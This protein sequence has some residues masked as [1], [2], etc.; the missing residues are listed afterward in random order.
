MSNAEHIARYGMKEQ[1]IALLDKA[2]I[3]RA[4]TLCG[5]CVICKKPIDNNGLHI[6]ASSAIYGPY[7]RFAWREYHGPCVGKSP[8][9]RKAL[10][11]AG[12]L[13]LFDELAR[14][15]DELLASPT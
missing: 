13:E 3:D 10:K 7:N 4:A 8:M 5:R 15:V 14:E 11:H 1:Q 2:G 9:V 6:N 12:F